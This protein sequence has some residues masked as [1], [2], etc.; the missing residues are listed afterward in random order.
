MREKIGVILLL[1]V[2]FTALSGIPGENDPPKGKKIMLADGELGSQSNPVKCDKVEGEEKYLN[3]LID[4]LGQSVQ[5]QRIGHAHPESNGNILDIFEITSGDGN[6]CVEICLDMYC[7]GAIENHPIKGF[8]I[9]DNPIVEYQYETPPLTAS[10]VYQMIVENGFYCEVI[11]G[12][13]FHGEGLKGV[14]SP[15]KSAFHLKRTI[16][17]GGRRSGVIETRSEKESDANQKGEK[18]IRLCW[19]P[20]LQN[21]TFEQA[22]KRVKKLNRKKERGSKTWRIPTLKELFSII[23]EDAKNPFP[24]AFDFPNDENLVFWTSTPVKKQGT[25]LDYDKKNKAYFVII[26]RY[27][28]KNN[29]CSL[30]FG[31]RNVEPGEKRQAKALLLPVFSERV[32]EGKTIISSGTPSPNEGGTKDKSAG[33]D[34]LIGANSLT[35]TA[36]PDMKNKKAAAQVPGFK[37]ESEKIP[38]FDDF[39]GLTK[40]APDPAKIPG[41]DDVPDNRDSES[42][43]KGIPEVNIAFFSWLDNSMMSNIPFDVNNKLRTTLKGL[44]P[45]LKK[46]LGVSLII[47]PVKDKKQTNRFYDIISDPNISETQKAKGVIKDIMSPGNIDIIISVKHSKWGDRL[48]G[49]VPIIVCG[50]DRRMY[51]KDFKTGQLLKDFEEVKKYIM[52]TTR[53]LINDRFQGK[54]TTVI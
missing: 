49:W 41:F 51:S 44:K 25:V 2:C 5:F 38:G 27:H 24:R 47:S 18:E 54:N 21:C 22:I 28:P 45:E 9:R 17:A 11:N 10:D 7:Q 34:S 1:F 20:G 12:S 15:V 33:K 13:D 19:Y 42:S 29:H 50:F 48:L 14:S 23:K 39:V 26:G 16:L 4:S 43:P 8:Y 35:A 31:F 40:P 3:R 53:T 36:K 37:K 52:S 6:L 30:S 46:K 32:Y